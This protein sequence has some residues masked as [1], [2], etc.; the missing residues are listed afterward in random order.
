MSTTITADLSEGAVVEIRSDDHV[1]RADEPVDLGGSDTGPDPYELLLG[2][3]AACTCITLS[4]Y[5]KRKGIALHSVSVRYEYDKIHADDCG[6]CDDEA[7]GWLDR[8]QAQIF[9]EGEF[10][11]EQRVRLGEVAVRCPVHKT[12]ANGISFT[13]EEVIIG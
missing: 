3:L 7:A 13:S 8:V 5:A 12:L 9:I 10:T 4:F 11:D 6:D 1:W 2:S